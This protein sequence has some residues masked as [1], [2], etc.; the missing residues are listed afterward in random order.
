MK[1][2]QFRPPR[3]VVGQGQAPAPARPSALPAERHRSAIVQTFPGFGIRN[4]GAVPLAAAFCP[5]EGRPSSPG[6]PGRCPG[7]PD[8]AWE[9]TESRPG[10]MGRWAGP[11]GSPD[12]GPRG[13]AVS[14]TLNRGPEA[15][16]FRPSSG[17]WALRGASGSGDRRG[18]P[19]SSATSSSSPRAVR[20]RSWRRRARSRCG[21]A[22]PR[23]GGCRRRRER[24]A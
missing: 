23:S 18:R 6:E 19:D 2:G 7:D 17:R 21:S 1:G 12:G 15:A 14:P 10:P 13:D 5:G 24:A 11:P 22:E 8:T 20:A 9:T 16:R 3:G 4:A